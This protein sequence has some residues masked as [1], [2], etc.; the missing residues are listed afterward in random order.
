MVC[1]L[2][3]GNRKCIFTSMK[4]WIV[5]TCLIFGVT[6]RAQVPSAVLFICSNAGKDRTLKVVDSGQSY[7][8]VMTDYLEKTLIGSSFVF[9]SK[10]TVVDPKTQSLVVINANGTDE[11]YALQIQP[12]DPNGRIALLTSNDPIG[13]SRAARKKVFNTLVPEASKVDTQILEC[14]D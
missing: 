7:Q 5:A 4:M 13:T 12:Q 10:N 2:T 9:K 11:S 8:I 3:L 6:A 14:T 1:Q